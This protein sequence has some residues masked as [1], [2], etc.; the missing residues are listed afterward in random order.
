MFSTNGEKN[1]PK[2]FDN[3]LIEK[4]E[5]LNLKAV[6]E[7]KQDYQ[8]QAICPFPYNEK[9]R[10]FIDMIWNLFELE[11]I[12]ILRKKFQNSPNLDEQFF[13]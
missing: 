12:P 11:V 4:K 13:S 5:P 9:Y 1:F 6:L 3:M 8:S 7:E 2:L 10:D